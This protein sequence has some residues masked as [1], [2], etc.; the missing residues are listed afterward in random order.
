MQ[1]NIANLKLDIENPV[2]KI[3]A[4]KLTQT[5]LDNRMNRPGVELCRDPAQFSL[6]ETDSAINLAIAQLRQRLAESHESLKAL[7]RRRVEL[8]HE[9]AVKTHTLFIDETECVAMRR[10]MCVNPY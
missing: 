1:D 3:A 4:L 9:L 5:R 8:E 10:S 2:G 7:D 6:I